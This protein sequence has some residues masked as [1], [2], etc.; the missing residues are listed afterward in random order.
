M[1][2]NPPLEQC[3]SW[4]T[5]LIQM[6][7]I[8]KC[9]ESTCYWAGA[10]RELISFTTDGRD[11]KYWS[12]DGIEW[13]DR[14]REGACPSQHQGRDCSFLNLSMHF[15]QSV[16]NQIKSSA[17]SLWDGIVS[18]KERG[19]CWASLYW[20][21]L[22]RTTFL[23]VVILDDRLGLLLSSFEV[24]T[25]VRAKPDSLS[26]VIF[27]THLNT[28]DSS[29]RVWWTM[30]LQRCYSLLTERKRTLPSLAWWEREDMF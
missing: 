20:S 28:D 14:S 27:L 15:F 23:S 17:D 30:N 25:S 26:I 22:L 1:A 6:F 18:V 3:L 8:S 11:L 29:Q 16:S 24:W 5:P 9:Q 2:M 19:Y 4:F 10:G 12:S 21:S 7:R 13:T